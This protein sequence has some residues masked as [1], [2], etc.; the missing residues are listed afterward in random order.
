MMRQAGR[1]AAAGVVSF[2]NVGCLLFGRCSI[3]S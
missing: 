2:I 3:C 1:C